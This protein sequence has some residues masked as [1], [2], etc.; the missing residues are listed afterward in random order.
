MERQCYLGV[1]RAGTGDSFQKCWI[2]ISLWN[3]LHSVSYFFFK[4]GH[5]AHDTTSQA[6]FRSMTSNTKHLKMW[7][8][9]LKR[10]LHLSALTLLWAKYTHKCLHNDLNWPQIESAGEL[11][12]NLGLNFQPDDLA[13]LIIRT[14]LKCLA[15]P[16][17][18]DHEQRKLFTSDKVGGEGTLKAPPL[19][20]HMSHGLNSAI[21]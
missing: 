5:R 2:S 3:Y 21:N 14:C 9:C 18:I 17:T 10:L 7:L 20:C 16:S 8:I 6:L 4:K 1:L 15:N 12:V 11:R 19:L 13:V